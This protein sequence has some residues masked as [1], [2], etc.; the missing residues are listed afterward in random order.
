MT[1]GRREANLAAR[2]QNLLVGPAGACPTAKVF[3]LLG[4]RSRRPIAR[5][6][7]RVS[8]LSALRLVLA[9]PLGVRG[10]VNRSHVSSS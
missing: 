3:L 8:L 2:T 6:I 9:L 4:P 5:S 7:P 1:R 10:P